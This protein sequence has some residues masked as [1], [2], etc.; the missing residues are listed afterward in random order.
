[1]LSDP[2][3]PGSAIYIHGNCASI[4]C[5]AI[6]DGPIEEVY[7]F[8]L[9]AKQRRIPIHIFPSKLDAAGL[10]EV[11]GQPNAAFWKQLAPGYAAFEANHRPPLVK[12]DGKTGAY[13][14]SAGR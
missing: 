11:E 9:D 7:L 6:E 3:A 13:V 5:I 1:V 10:K 4:G 12:V 14:V 8:A 2:K